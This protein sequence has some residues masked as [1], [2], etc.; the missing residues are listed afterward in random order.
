MIV[1]MMGILNKIVATKYPW[2]VIRI[3]PF[4]SL[5]LETYE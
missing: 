5:M 4:V 3:I 1:L 2:Y